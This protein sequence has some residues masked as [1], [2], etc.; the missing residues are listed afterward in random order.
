MAEVILLLLA[1]VA[2]WVAFYVFAKQKRWSGL[3][4]HGGGFISACIVF[5]AIAT[6]IM[7]RSELTYVRRRNRSVRWIWTSQ[8]RAKHF[9]LNELQYRSCKRL[10][11]EVKPTK[12]RQPDGPEHKAAYKRWDESCGMEILLPYAKQYKYRAFRTVHW[13]GHNN[14]SI[15]SEKSANRSSWSCFRQI[16]AISRLVPLDATTKAHATVGFFMGEGRLYAVMRNAS[17]SLPAIHFGATPRP[18][19]VLPVSG[20]RYLGATFRPALLLPACSCR[21]RAG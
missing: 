6:A 21:C 12:S 1:F 10:G 17:L 19:H 20:S 13:S 2:A 9:G 18:V 16:H 14:P 7:P 15:R 11:L 5:G 3:V 8:Y 4:A